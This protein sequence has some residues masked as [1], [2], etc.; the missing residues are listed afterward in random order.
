MVKL[1]MMAGEERDEIRR[2]D[3]YRKILVQVV[4]KTPG[5][6]LLLTAY[7]TR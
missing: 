5:F 2:R 7:Y 3:G 6:K 1:A 4:S